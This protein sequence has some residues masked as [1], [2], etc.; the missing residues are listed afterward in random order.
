MEERLISPEATDG[1]VDPPLRPRTLDEFIGQRQLC[2]NL[3]VFID[4]A[5]QRREA[6]DHLRLAGPPAP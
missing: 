3:R 1:D 6:L 2:D 4:A 5:R